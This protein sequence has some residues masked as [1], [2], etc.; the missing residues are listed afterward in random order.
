MK[1]DGI[2]S[3]TANPYRLYRDTAHGFI[4]GV[5]A[6]IAD[7]LGIRP[8]NVRLAAVLA[9]MF[10]F[11]PTAIAYVVLALVLQPRPSGLY[12]SRDEENFWRGVAA[13][14]NQTLQS[15]Q[16]KFRSLEQRLARMETLV[17]AE[18]FELRRKF[19]DI[20]D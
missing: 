1:V 7:Y 3:R 5:C 9:L 10:F 4:A 13:A 2:F 19:R 20:G 14:P 15:L 16:Y 11:V 18:E 8:W 12:E 17:T 6:G